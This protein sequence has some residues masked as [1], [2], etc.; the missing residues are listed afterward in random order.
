MWPFQNNFCFWF[1]KPSFRW[2][3]CTCLWFPPPVFWAG[4]GPVVQDAVAKIRHY[5]SHRDQREQQILAAVQKGAGKPF[6]SMELVRII[7]KVYIK[8]NLNQRR[9][10]DGDDG[11]VYLLPFLQDTPEHLHKAANVNVV[12]HLTKLVKEG[13]ISQGAFLMITSGGEETWF[14]LWVKTDSAGVR[15]SDVLFVQSIANIDGQ[16]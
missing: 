13:K 15:Q 8:T 14:N 12:H 6:T 16:Q 7:Y 5:I 1:R 4:H 3:I 11:K 9:D 2:G 10:W